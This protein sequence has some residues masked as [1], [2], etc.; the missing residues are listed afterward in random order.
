MLQ[1]GFDY[2]EPLFTADSGN[3]IY[4]S[5]SRISS[6]QV[7]KEDTLD[8]AIKYVRASRRGCTLI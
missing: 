7:A 1:L 6:V 8:A 5:S 2:L 4:V 3:D